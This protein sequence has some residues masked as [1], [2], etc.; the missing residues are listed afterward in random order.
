MKTM[1]MMS[2]T[3]R[4][5]EVDLDLRE[6]IAASLNDPRPALPADT[7]FDEL[8]ALIDEIDAEQ[9]ES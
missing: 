8:D 2:L 4:R 5:S 6:A 3:G 1:N 7:V 9:Y